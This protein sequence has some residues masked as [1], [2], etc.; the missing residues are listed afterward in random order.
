ML[1][2][3]YYSGWIALNATLAQIKPK[4]VF[5]LGANE[6]GW[7]VTFLNIPDCQIH[8]FEPIPSMKDACLKRYGD[9]P[10]I[11]WNTV[12]IADVEQLSD[13]VDVCLAWALLPKALSIGKPKVAKYDTFRMQLI[14]IDG[15]IER[16]GVSPDFIKMDIDGYEY[17]ALKGGQRFLKSHPVPMLFE[18]SFLPQLLNDSIEDM[19]RLIYDL[20][21]E[22]VSLDGKY[23]CPSAKEMMEH[24]NFPHNTS[25]DLLLLPQGFDLGL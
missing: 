3:L 18:Y 6:G 7:C 9:N 4:T 16:T 13:P 25:Y 20:G 14:T 2:P 11:I 5:D 22:A 15:Y 19:C 17:K 24:S 8:C 23:R 12:G 1:G 10:R 21:Y